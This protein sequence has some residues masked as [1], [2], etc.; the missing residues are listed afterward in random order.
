MG[1][2]LDGILVFVKIRYV[3]V[4]NGPSAQHIAAVN[5]FY[6]INTHRHTHISRGPEISQV[7]LYNKHTLKSLATAEI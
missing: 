4:S 3:P 1:L 7:L 6:V 2:T 5:K